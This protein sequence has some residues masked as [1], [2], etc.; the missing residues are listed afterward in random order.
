[1]KHL[2][3]DEIENYLLGRQADSEKIEEH[4]L[5]CGVCVDYAQAQE[6]IIEVIRQC[7]RR[8]IPKRTRKVKLKVMT[9]HQNPSVIPAR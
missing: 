3:E 4:L 6:Q 2:S 7:L 9:A 8:P 1:M 5:I